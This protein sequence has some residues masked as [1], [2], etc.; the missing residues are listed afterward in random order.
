MWYI[1]GAFSVSKVLSLVQWGQRKRTF[2]AV[3]SL[4]G[5]A[6]P[7]ASWEYRSRR[8]ERVKTADQAARPDPAVVGVGRQDN[9]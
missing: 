3:Y 2:M 7:A 6:R 8:A 5:R 9:Q 1:F 4:P